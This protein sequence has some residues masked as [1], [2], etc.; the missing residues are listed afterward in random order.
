MPPL[1]HAQATQRFYSY[2]WPLRA[3]LL[4]TA[5]FLT[6]SNAEAEDLVQ[7]TMMKAF[8]AIDSLDPDA[9]PQA[10]LTTILRNTRI[11]RLRAA[12]RAP[13]TVSLDK[14]TE[15]ADLPAPAATVASPAPDPTATLEEFSD[16]D[17]IHALQK[18]PEDIR[19]TLL[20]VD[21]DGLEYEEA[22]TIM[23]IPPGTAKSRV[24]RGRHMLRNLLL[25]KT[26]ATPGAS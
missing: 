26:P 20:L 4:R 12:G 14:I 25:E 7:E 21:V 15:E 3:M 6:P 23:Q 22:A 13:E 8:R 2:I 24:H 9:S 19:W 10:W 18:L 11:D 5:S 16:R 17:L 1:S